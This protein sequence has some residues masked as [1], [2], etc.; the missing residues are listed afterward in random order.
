MNTKKERK[1][2]NQSLRKLIKNEN[3]FSRE[4]SA[5]KAYIIKSFRDQGICQGNHDMT[6]EGMKA[7]LLWKCGHRRL[8]IY[9]F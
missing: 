5:R 1:K 2:P 7:S 8:S 3:N 4:S 9:D 6:W